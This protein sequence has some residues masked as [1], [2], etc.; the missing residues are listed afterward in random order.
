M[1]ELNRGV[2]DRVRYIDDIPELGASQGDEGVIVE[3][4]PDDDT[5]TYKVSFPNVTQ[6][7]WH[8][9]SRIEMIGQETVCG[10]QERALKAEAE[11]KELRAALKTLSEG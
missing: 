8:L 6:A 5:M 3:V 4:D 10:W 7:Y 2:G 11:L 9:N 1:I